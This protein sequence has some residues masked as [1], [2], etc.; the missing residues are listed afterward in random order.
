MNEKYEDKWSR[1]SGQWSD[2]VRQLKDGERAVDEFKKWTKEF[3]PAPVISLTKMEI[4]LQVVD[5]DGNMTRRTLG[6]DALNDWLWYIEQ[7][8]VSKGYTIKAH[9]SGSR[10]LSPSEVNDDT[11][12]DICVWAHE[13]DIGR[14][15]AN[16]E[17]AIFKLESTEHY[18]GL[19]AGGFVSL[20]S[21]AAV[22][23][24]VNVCLTSNERFYAKHRLATSIGIKLGLQG[25][26]ARVAWFRKILY[27]EE[28][29]AG[30]TALMETV[31]PVPAAVPVKTAGVLKK[32][33][34]KRIKLPEDYGK[35]PW[36]SI[37][38][39]QIRNP[40]KGRPK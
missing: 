15:M 36:Y 28:I 34:R 27:G 22:G 31:V 29:P 38:T 4:H 23:Y 24:N 9:V 37:N 40:M 30:A 16:L 3:P 25:K 10:V 20:R 33:N 5:K 2:D 6:D 8:L 26:P 32:G 12:Y 17:T 13:A 35:P 7:G 1:W 18:A 14:I 11:D 39:Q 19:A 21:T